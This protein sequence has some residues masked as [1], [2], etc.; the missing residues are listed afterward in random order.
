MIS[1]NGISFKHYLK[2]AEM[3]NKRIAV[4][5]DNDK[6]EERI[7]AAS[8]Y[9]NSHR[10]QHI[11]MG[12]NNEEWTWEACIYEKNKKLLDDIIDI[13]KGAQYLFHGK[14]YGQVLGKMLNNKVD[15]AY[16][17]LTSGKDYVSPQYVRKAIEW[18]NK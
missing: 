3:T 15:S 8:N 1:C 11:F 5:T 18:I 6:N 16:L 13:Q 7:E 10:D 9:N 14:D 12:A 17:M 2:I 4:I